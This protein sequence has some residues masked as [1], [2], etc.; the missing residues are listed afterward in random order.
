MTPDEFRAL[1]LRY[2][3]VTETVQEGGTQLFT[4]SRRP[5]ARIRSG[6]SRFFDVM[7]RRE[8]LQ[9]AGA[10][11]PELFVPLPGTW[12]K[13]GYLQINAKCGESTFVSALDAAWKNA[14]PR[15]LARRHRKAGWVGFRSTTA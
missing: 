2:P 1:V 10:G 4:V 9:A 5:F 14:A 3:D 8:D 6:N 13:P 11:E 15:W 12:R 7:L